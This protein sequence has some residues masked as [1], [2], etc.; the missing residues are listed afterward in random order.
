MCLLDVVHACDSSI[1]LRVRSEA[2]ETEATAAAGITVF[3]DNLRSLVK[4]AWG[5]MKV[6]YSLLDLTELLELLAKDGIIGVP[7]QPSV[8]A[9]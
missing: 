6:T 4:V 3:D 7:G 5:G 8:V 1:G 9:C 2:N